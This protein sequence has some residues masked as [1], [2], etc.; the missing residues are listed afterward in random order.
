M[1]T[2]TWKQDDEEFSKHLFLQKPQHLVT[3]KFDIKDVNFDQVSQTGR[4]TL[5]GFCRQTGQR[6]PCFI[7]CSSDH[8]VKL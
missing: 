5:E 8:Q 3:I 6:F 7:I 1:K 2:V 4:V